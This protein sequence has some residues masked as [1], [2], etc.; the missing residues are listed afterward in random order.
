MRMRLGSLLVV[1]VSVGFLGCAS[2][3]EEISKVDEA[4]LGDTPC[5]ATDDPDACYESREPR[6]PFPT[7]TVQCF[8]GCPAGMIQT[9]T[10]ACVGTP[11]ERPS[12]WGGED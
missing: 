12:W 3:P 11:V 2:A 1:M 6:V 9:D 5:Y 10:C 4:R 7:P 8:V